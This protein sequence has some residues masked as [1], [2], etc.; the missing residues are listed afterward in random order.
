MLQKVFLAA[1]I[2]CILPISNLQSE[3][4]YEGCIELPGMPTEPGCCG[5]AYEQGVSTSMLVATVLIGTI[6]LAVIAVALWNTGNCNHH[7]HCHNRH[8]RHDHHNN[9]HKR[10]S[11][12][13]H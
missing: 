8:D 4:L 9:H 13:S 6:G 7:N 2:S 12:G 5:I 10:Q 1:M 11:Y 3:Q